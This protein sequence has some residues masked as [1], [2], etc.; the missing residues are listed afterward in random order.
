MWKINGL[1]NLYG[2]FIGQFDEEIYKGTWVPTFFGGFVFL[3]CSG[4]DRWGQVA[5]SPLSHHQAL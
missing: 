1:T 4:D 3:V 5:F 2:L